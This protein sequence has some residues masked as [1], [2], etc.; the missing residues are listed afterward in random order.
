[1]FTCAPV[2]PTSTT[3]QNASDRVIEFHTRITRRS[4]SRLLHHLKTQRPTYFVNKRGRKQ[5]PVDIQLH[6]GLFCLGFYGNAAAFEAAST[7]FGYAVGTI[8]NARNRFVTA[9]VSLT[10]D[11]IKWPNSNERDELCK[12]VRM[13]HGY[14]RAFF[15][16]DGTTHNF[17]FVP[18]YDRTSWFDRKSNYSMQALV[19]CD[20][21]LQHGL[22]DAASLKIGNTICDILLCG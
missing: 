4:F 2:K 10:S 8:Y 13:R 7:K 21:N 3:L 6:L 20:T 18:K 19:T 12:Q 5:L 22:G 14:H 11:F 17:A 15:L 16:V 1:M 9:L